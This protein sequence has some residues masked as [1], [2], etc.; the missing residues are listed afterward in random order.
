MKEVMPVVAS[1]G[2]SRF[3]RRC[4]WCEFNLPLSCC[5]IFGQLNL[6]RPKTTKSGGSGGAES[7]K[8]YINKK[9]SFRHLIA[10]E[11]LGI[12]F[13]WKVHVLR[14]SSFLKRRFSRPFIF[15]PGHHRGAWN[16]SG[17]VMFLLLILLC[18]KS[19]HLYS[20]RVLKWFEFVDRSR[21]KRKSF[22][23]LTLGLGNE[24]RNCSCW[25]F[26]DNTSQG[27]ASSLKRI[28]EN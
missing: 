22:L 5:F 4:D 24:E 23:F 12:L 16:Q 17:S 27:W 3:K 13:H 14:Q 11:I 19:W 26:L 21:F 9:P 1:I 2:I 20:K 28:S 15:L 10:D 25:G 7:P 8:H 6:L 18:L